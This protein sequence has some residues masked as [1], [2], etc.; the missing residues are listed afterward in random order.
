MNKNL[1]EKLLKTTTEDEFM[2]IILKQPEDFEHNRDL[3][4]DK[5]IEHLLK[6]SDLTK[7]EFEF[8]F[9][10]EPPKDDFINA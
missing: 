8:S 1:I 3:W 7:E 2:E 6:I 4:D 5:V 10:L 9:T